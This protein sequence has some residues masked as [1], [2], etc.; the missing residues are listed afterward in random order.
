LLV[1]NNFQLENLNG[2]LSLVNVG[3]SVYVGNNPELGLC[4]GLVPLLDQIDDGTVGPGPGAAGVPDV[5][6]SVTLANNGD[7]SCNS[8]SLLADSSAMTTLTVNKS[9]SDGNSTS[10]PVEVS[11]VGPTTL[12]NVTDGQASQ[13]DP[14]VFEIKR[15]VPGFLSTCTAIEKSVPAGYTVDQSDCENIELLDDSPAA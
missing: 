7:E 3:E 1:Y 2:L 14:A 11:C 6:N 8:L 9:F 15:F 10:V 4:N 13:S 5:A 12:I